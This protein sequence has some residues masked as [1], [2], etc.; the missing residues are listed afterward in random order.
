MTRHQGEQYASRRDFWLCL[1]RAFAPPAAGDYCRAFKE[2]LP[3]DLDAIALEVGLNIRSELDGLAAAA[4]LL[5]DALELQRLYASLFVTPPVP[6]FMN[7]AVYQDSAFLGPSENDLNDWYARHGFER[8]KEFRDLNDHVAVQ[9]EFIGL[10]YQKA[11]DRAFS[12]QDMEGLA[13]A[14]EAERFLSQYPKRWVTA[15][16]GALETTC[17][18]RGAN[19]V[20]THLARIAWHAVEHHLENSA[21]RFEV[22][23]GTFPTG[24][25]RGTGPLNADDLAEIAYRLQSTGLSFEHVKALPEWSDAAFSA[26][27]SQG[28]AAVSPALEERA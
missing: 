4:R 25:A 6:V 2:D 12:G 28:D 13:F 15:F 20:Y 11:A 26:R 18:E 16:L 24:S 27:L 7:T 3:S 23:E 22:D 9:M 8:H 17:V 10:L 21:V 14:T 19:G 5:P 1:A